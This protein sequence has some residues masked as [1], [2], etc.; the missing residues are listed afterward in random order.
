MSLQ[1]TGKD[2]AINCLS[3]F[4]QVCL[5]V[6]HRKDACYIQ[7]LQR[8]TIQLMF[9]RLMYLWCLF[10]GIAYFAKISDEHSII[11]HFVT[12]RCPFQGIYEF[13]T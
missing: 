3:L 10:H 5:E 4:A 9:K 12:S 2:F 8:T 6:Y 13:S 1:M 11:F 7:E